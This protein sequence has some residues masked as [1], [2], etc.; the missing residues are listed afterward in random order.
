M[1]VR[2]ERLDPAP[3]AQRGTLEYAASCE[4]VRDIL[5]VEL[6]L[7]EAKRLSEGDVLV[8]R[9]FVRELQ[10]VIAR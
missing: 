8:T 1:K 10:K 7:E 9:F 5:I 3:E 4:R 2:L 6:S